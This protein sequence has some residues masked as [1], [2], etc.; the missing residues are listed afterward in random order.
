MRVT[1]FQD[2]YKKGND[3]AH[4]IQ[5]A[6]ALKRIQ[7]GN[8]ATTIEAIRNGAKDFKKKLPVVLF[9]GEFESRNDEALKQGYFI[10]TH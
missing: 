3:D 2:L 5:L 6:T 4:V 9:S 1:I 7:E 10:E 8:S